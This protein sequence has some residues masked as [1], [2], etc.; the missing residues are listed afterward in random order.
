MMYMN[1][2]RAT[3]EK[4]NN[5][6]IITRQNSHVNLQSGKYIAKTREQTIIMKI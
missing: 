2:K 3:F 6:C 5:N 4:L 1:T